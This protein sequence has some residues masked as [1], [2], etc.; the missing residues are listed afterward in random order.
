MHDSY[1][2]SF[3]F[4]LSQES[5]TELWT[6]SVKPIVQVKQTALTPSSSFPLVFLLLQDPSSTRDYPLLPAPQAVCQISCQHPAPSARAGMAN[7]WNQRNLR[8]TELII[9][10]KTKEPPS[11]RLCSSR[12]PYQHCPGRATQTLPPLLFP[13]SQLFT[14]L[15]SVSAKLCLC[16]SLSSLTL[17][18]SARN[19][20]SSTSPGVRVKIQRQ[21]FLP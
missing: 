1:S 19:W 9:S 3:W 16:C 8:L 2:L 18:G 11:M 14:W 17:Q 21:N 10:V 6:W 13:V 12:A 5:F 15:I 7:L 4:S 20:I